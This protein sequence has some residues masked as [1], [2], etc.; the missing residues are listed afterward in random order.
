MDKPHLLVSTAGLPTHKASALA[1][2]MSRVANGLH[3][4]YGGATSHMR[5]TLI[6]QDDQSD[7]D[8][9]ITPLFN[10]KSW[11]AYD[12]PPTH[13]E[14]HIEGKGCFDVT[15]PPHLLYLSIHAGPCDLRTPDIRIEAMGGARLQSLDVSA[16]T[17]LVLAPS[18]LGAC[19]ASL[20]RLAIPCE[21]GAGDDARL[22]ALTSLTLRGPMRFDWTRCMLPRL[23]HLC[24]IGVGVPL[25]ELAACSPNLRML[26]V[27]GDGN[28]THLSFPSGAP[29]SELDTLVLQGPMMIVD[30][31]DCTLRALRRIVA[32]DVHISISSLPRHCPQ[33]HTLDV[34][35]L[36]I[37]EV[38]D[39]PPSLHTLRFEECLRDRLTIRGVTNALRSLTIESAHFLQCVDMINRDA[40]ALALDLLVVNDCPQLTDTRF[41]HKDGAFQECCQNSR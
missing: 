27:V 34:R 41:L 39:L 24:A 11:G 7:E 21:L 37:P 33:L 26:E 13:L 8:A 28:R 23:Q 4:A 25:D 15:I 32:E 38:V 16:E 18:F 10:E 30:W 2:T 1:H 9:I 22:V 20:E 19:G 40:P 14:I 3:R 5:V 6:A 31:N 29:L 12:A 35:G 17:H 36:F